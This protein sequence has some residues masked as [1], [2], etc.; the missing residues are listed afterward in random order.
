MFRRKP[1]TGSV[2]LK[3][4]RP[5]LNA[6]LNFWELHHKTHSRKIKVTDQWKRYEYTLMNPERNMVQFGVSLGE[7]G[8]IWADDVQVELG[9]KATPYK[10]SALDE[11]KFSSAPEKRRKLCL[12]SGSPLRKKLR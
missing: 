8:V 4:D 6:T 12:M 2:W 7:P 1:V 10:T 5:D 3:A 9:E 11:D